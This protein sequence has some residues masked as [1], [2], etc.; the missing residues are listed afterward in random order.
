MIVAAI[1]VQ[2]TGGLFL[3]CLCVLQEVGVARG[4][5]VGMCQDRFHTL[6]FGDARLWVMVVAWD[7]QSLGEI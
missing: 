4:I 6:S 2:I 3:Q 7:W 1:F 5:V